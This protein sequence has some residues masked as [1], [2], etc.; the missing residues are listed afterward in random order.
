MSVSEMRKVLALV[1][2]L[3]QYVKR[4]VSD[5]VLY[6]ICAKH[7]CKSDKA[8]TKVKPAENAKQ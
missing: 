4:G 7:I 8:E 5:D 2:E 6:E 1:D 3:K